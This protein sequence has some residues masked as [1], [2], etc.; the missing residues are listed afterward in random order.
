MPLRP[1]LA[2][3]PILLVLVLMA[4]FGRSAALSGAAGLALAA[5]L[6]FGPFALDR[7][8][9]VGIFASFLGV[10]LEGMFLAATVVAIVWPALALH[11]WQEETGALERV[12]AALGVLTTDPA[13]RT[14]LVGW[15][16][17]LFVEGAAGFGTPV[18]LAAP[19]LAGFGLAPARAVAVALIGHAVGVSFGAVGTPVLAQ[20]EL[21]SVAERALAGP[22]A[23]IHGL[24]GPGLAI[25]AVASGRGHAAGPRTR[26]RARSSGRRAVPQ[27]LGA[28]RARDRAR[29]AHAARRTRGRG[30][31]RAAPRTVPPAFVRGAPARL[32]S[33]P[34][35]RADRA[36]AGHPPRST[37]AGARRG[38]GV[39]LAALGQVRRLRASPVPS[40]HAARGGVPSRRDLARGASARP[41]ADA[42]ADRAR[43]GP[44]GGWV[45]S[46]CSRCRG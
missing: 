43:P 2:A 11:R 28:D 12:R 33:R 46:R 18:A 41:A 14:L 4:G 13:A 7:A 1:W 26:A 24:L 23:L 27:P 8:T 34:V 44:S 38:S 30:R 39:G 25:A 6:A 36:R 9:G 15:F 21:V 16:F 10:A 29:A 35:S 19:L 31:L 32:G 42:G 37:G 3:S 5:G 45:W 22:T 17:A 20:A 40:R